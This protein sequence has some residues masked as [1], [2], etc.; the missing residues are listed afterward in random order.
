M[1]WEVI[2]AAVVILLLGLILACLI[3]IDDLVADIRNDIYKESD[4]R[5]P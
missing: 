3:H 5:I 4:R 1:I 2:V